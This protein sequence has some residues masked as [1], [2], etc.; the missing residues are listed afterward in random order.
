MQAILEMHILSFDAMIQLETF[1][2]LYALSS[3]F[4]VGIR[5]E[6]MSSLFI[7]NMNLH[8]LKAYCKFL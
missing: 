1:F 7:L 5:W 4:D 6:Y 3:A 8:T 2:S